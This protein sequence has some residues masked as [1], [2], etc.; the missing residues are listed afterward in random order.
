M[1]KLNLIQRV[2][3]VFI[4]FTST[5]HSQATLPIVGFNDAYNYTIGH[6]SVT[7]SSGLDIHWYGG[8]RFG[9]WSS[10]SV[11][12]ITNG[13]VGI[14]TTTPTERLTVAGN[15]SSREVKVTVDAGADFVFEKDYNLKSLESLDKFIKENKHLPEIA[16][17]QEMQ[18]DGIN[19]SKM[20]IK[21]LQKIEELTLYIIEQ[22]KKIEDLQ[23]RLIKIE[24]PSN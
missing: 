12:Q 17:A 4:F 14:G 24:S 10:R 22:N 6:Y 21:L 18:N 8:I 5:I 11:M 2:V 7:G 9:D 1:K 20:N 19:L 23:N 15:I 16:S 3:V 13:K